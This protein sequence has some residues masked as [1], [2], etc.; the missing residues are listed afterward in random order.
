MQ[1]E[2]EKNYNVFY[3]ERIKK[4]HKEIIRDNARISYYLFLISVL[5]QV[6]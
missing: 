2:K 5:Y 3:E 6:I 4:I 1:L